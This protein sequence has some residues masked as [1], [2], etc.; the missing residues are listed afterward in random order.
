MMKRSALTPEALETLILV[1]EEGSF[2]AAARK[3]G[4]VPSSLTYSMRQLE[5]D[6][7][8]LLFDR[9]SKHAK[10]TPAGLELLHEGQRLLLEIDSIA[11]RVKR[12]ATGW[13]PELTIAFDSLISQKV[14]LEI[15]SDFLST[16]PPTRVRLRHEVLRGTWETLVQGEADIALGV[17]VNQ[18]LPPGIQI[19]A[20][21][22]LNFVFAVSPSHPLAKVEGFISN[23]ILMQHRAIAVADSVREFE[24]MTVGLLPGQDVLTVPTFAMKIQAQLLGLGCGFIL[25]PMARPYLA[26]GMLIE[27]QVKNDQRV[28][29]IA[30]AWRGSR[31]SKKNDPSSGL[32]LRWWLDALSKPRTRHALLQS[33]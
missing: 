27:K 1:A 5:E 2:A 19:Q 11:N 13:E 25:E 9:T 7:D 20:L 17:A 33:Y 18:S 14:L 4:K 26:A 29:E 8:V 15:V 6:L 31:S 23:E 10:L 22:D 32:A 21:G 12:V 16:S 28:A 30:Y 24:P 3:L